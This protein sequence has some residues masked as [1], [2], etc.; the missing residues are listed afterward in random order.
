MPFISWTEIE[1]FHNIRK[2]T[3]SKPETYGENSK[4][5]YKAKVKLHGTNAA[6]RHEHNGK[7]V[8]QSRSKDLTAEE[9][10][11]GFA[12]WVLSN[13]DA[14]KAAIKPGYIVFGEWCGSGIQNGVAVSSLP[15]KYFAV[16]AVR[17][18]DANNNKTDKL[19]IEP[20]EIGEI[21]NISQIPNIYILPWFE[22]G[23]EYLVDWTSL[24]ENL[25]PIVSKINEDVLSIEECDPWVREIFNVSGMGEGLVFYPMSHL[26]YENFSFLCFKAKGEKHKNIKSSKPAQID[27]ASAAS[28]SQ[29]A[30]LVLTSARLEQGV[31][32]VAG[33]LSF[34]LK[35]TGK[36]IDWVISDV[37]KETQDELTASNLKFNDVKKMIKSR[38]SKWYISKAKEL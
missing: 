2:L 38:A 36:F 25:A 18:L 23:K 28:I 35:L 13:E 37:E 15:K 22:N 21:M 33:S 29:F 27:P 11:A 4:V 32:S 9:D 17:L 12:K 10:N 3:L 34:D 16:F 5:L 24:G 14:F 19:I 1:G 7:I 31:T 26:G 6:I 30:D 20:D 8:C